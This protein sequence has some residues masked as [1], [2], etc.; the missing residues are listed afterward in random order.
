MAFHSNLIRVSCV[1]V[2]AVAALLL[3]VA[4]F[5]AA[6]LDEPL[7]DAI[8]LIDGEAI[9]VSGPMSVETVHGL[10]KTV[11][12]SG[13]D[14]RVKSGAARI[15]LIEGGQ[16]TICG[17]AHL[18]L[19][20]SGGSLT[21]ALDIGILH[22]R[23]E[24]EP[25]L[26]VYTAQIQARTISIGDGPQDVLVGFESPGAM[27]VRAT[28]GAIRIEQQLTG[29]SVI[30]PQTGDVLLL[31]GQLDSL[32][33][34]AGHCS[35]ELEVTKAAPPQ[36]SETGSLATTEENRSQT[37]E[38]NANASI[39]ATEKPAVKEEP[40]YQVFMPP[41]V[42]D[43]KAKVQ[44]EVDPRIIILV[45]RVR[46]RPTLIF[47]GR[48]EGEQVAAATPPPAP[49]SSSAGTATKTATTASGSFAD[50]VR[51][52]VRKLWSRGS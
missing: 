34:S 17:P 30:I 40:I 1:A 44:P 9:V 38:A 45:R 51:N 33:S 47:Q 32:R 18:S 11:L 8:G 26:T 31:N 5:A 42:Y 22:A 29:Q 6:R 46:V 13:S 3:C 37:V 10:V 49:V 25:A 43:A 23:I 4:H 12:R 2:L 21:V 14:V 36:P 48:V 28:R 24:R 50:R 41:L 19:L 39:G 27:C 7:S 35:C 15:D 16:I 52:Y 20:K